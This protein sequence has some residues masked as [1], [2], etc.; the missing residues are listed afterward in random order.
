MVNMDNFAAHY[1]ECPRAVI[2][3]KKK[4]GEFYPRELAYR[5]LKKCKESMTKCKYCD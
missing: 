4:C 2:L 3:C 1:E 5:H